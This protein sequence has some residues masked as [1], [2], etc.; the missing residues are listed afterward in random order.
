[1]PLGYVAFEEPRGL[2][3]ILQLMGDKICHFPKGTL[4]PSFPAKHFQSHRYWP[5]RAWKY[6]QELLQ[7]R[8]SGWFCQISSQIHSVQS[9]KLISTKPLNHYIQWPSKL[10]LLTFSCLLAW[11]SVS[12]GNLFKYDDLRGWESQRLLTFCDILVLKPLD[13]IISET[14]N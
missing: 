1:M 6:S 12:L 9:T 3:Y 2:Q 14:K 8:C 11:K 10:S 5:L 13:F 7:S 4:R